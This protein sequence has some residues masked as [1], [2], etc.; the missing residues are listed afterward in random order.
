MDVLSSGDFDDDVSAMMTTT[1]NNSSLARLTM[2]TSMTT[3]DCDGDIE[4]L[5]ATPTPSKEEGEC[6]DSTAPAHGG[7]CIFQPET[8]VSAEVKKQRLETEARLALCCA[9]VDCKVQTSREDVLFYDRHHKEDEDKPDRQRTKGVCFGYAEVESKRRTQI[10]AELKLNASARDWKPKEPMY[11]EAPYPSLFWRTP[12][13]VFDRLGE[14]AW[15]VDNVQWDNPLYRDGFRPWV[16]AGFFQT[17]VLD[18]I[19]E[20]AM[21][22]TNICRRGHDCATY[23]IPV[24]CKWSSDR[25]CVC[26][27]CVDVKYLRVEHFNSFLIC[28]GC[29][30]KDWEPFRATGYV[31]P[32][33]EFGIEESR[34]DTQRG[35]L[36]GVETGLDA[37]Q[38]WSTVYLAWS[39]AIAIYSDPNVVI[40]EWGVDALNLVCLRI[41]SKFNEDDGNDLCYRES[42][43]ILR[44]R[45]DSKA[46]RNLEIRLLDYFQ[47]DF[48]NTKL[49]RAMRPLPESVWEVASQCKRIWALFA[50]GDQTEVDAKLPDRSDQDVQSDCCYFMKLLASDVT[51]VSYVIGSRFDSKTAAELPPLGKTQS[52]LEL[53]RQRAQQRA[54]ITAAS[55]RVRSSFRVETPAS[56]SSAAVP[57]LIS[58]PTATTPAPSPSPQSPS[59]SI[60]V[61][62]QHRSPVELTSY[63]SLNVSEVNPSKTKKMRTD[64]QFSRVEASAM[65]G[66]P[67]CATPWPLVSTAAVVAAAKPSILSKSSSGRF[68][69]GSS[70][71]ESAR[72]LTLVAMK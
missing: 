55:Q 48:Y 32:E 1:T 67:A 63:R 52:P 38:N 16:T 49:A 42:D 9:S 31:S 13:K 62:I 35:K 27:G 30:E 26:K 37:K 56:P 72:R 60:E 17:R 19:L 34:I 57:M 43:C 33:R 3:T 23:H 29:R 45:F 69:S 36:C 59:T 41:A 46:L 28:S 21:A 10:D 5:T 61:L 12:D 64:G 6:E 51:V 44:H 4:L 53:R 11:A 8:P 22:P 20:L 71:L 66:A 40:D 68:V 7:Q 15:V 58:T 39:L 18:R 70:K 54:K 24:E 14:F 65:R 50:V 25:C 47:F 2:K